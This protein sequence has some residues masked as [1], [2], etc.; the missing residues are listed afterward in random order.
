[1]D[2]DEIMELL[3]DYHAVLADGASLVE[4]NR[5]IA[6]TTPYKNYA[7]L[8]RAAFG[9]PPR[10][11]PGVAEEAEAK[12]E[13]FERRAERQPGIGGLAA[14][15]VVDR[16]LG[17]PG[18]PDVDVARATGDFGR[19]AAQGATFGFADELVGMLGGDTEASRQRMEDLR[20]TE[21]TATAMGEVAGAAPSILIPGGAALRAGGVARGAAISGGASA[22]AGALVG[23]GEAEG[24]LAERLD[25]AL[26]GA[27]I[28]GVVGVPLGGAGVWIGRFLPRIFGQRGPRIARTLKRSAGVDRTLDEAF[29]AADEAKRAVSREVYQPLDEAFK[30][31]TD[32]GVLEALQQPEL[33]T[34][35][36]SVSKDVVNGKRGPS[37]EELQ[38]IRRKGRKAAKRSPEIG[39]A[40]DVLDQEMQI[41]IPGL[42][43]ADRAYAQASE[44]VEALETSRRFVGKPSALTRR[45]M[46][47]YSP[48]AQV[49]FR[50]GMI[51]EF[52]QRLERRASQWKPSGAV[53]NMLDMGPEMRARLRAGFPNDEVFEQFL[54]DVALERGGAR[55]QRYVQWLTAGA[56]AAY[57]YNRMFGG[58][59]GGGSQ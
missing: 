48:D 29:E 16:L 35:V 28:G 6:A 26:T 54:E 34:T 12:A 47:S 3:A 5:E 11:A 53:Q 38:A 55:L 49:A 37:F 42:G 44:I 41:A 33:R 45:A 10:A 56:V 24:S 13:A 50:E 40:T 31:V 8:A 32:P 20:L 58:G 36:R 59:G 23:L 25:E 4:V 46:E 2:H 27:A 43:D 1:M 21:P 30:E 19:A 57:G 14:S 39:N 18:I 7:E 52:A 9:A 15:A 22:G 51:H 17:G